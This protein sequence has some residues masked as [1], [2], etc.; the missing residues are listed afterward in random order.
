MKVSLLTQICSHPSTPS[1]LTH[2]PDARKEIPGHRCNLFRDK[3]ESLLT[4]TKSPC[5]TAT[6]WIVAAQHVR[7]C[8]F[9][10][11]FCKRKKNKIC[12]KYV[13]LKKLFLSKEIFL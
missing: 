11:V 13:F 7:P 6:F 4:D 3:K 2:N 9:L 1:L 10:Q 12:R 8:Q 5:C